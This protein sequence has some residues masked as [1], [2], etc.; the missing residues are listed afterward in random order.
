MISYQTLVPALKE[1]FPEAAMTEDYIV[2]NESV[3]YAF[4]SDLVDYLRD[5]YQKGA[6]NADDPRI[7]KMFAIITELENLPGQESREIVPAGFFESMLYGE[8]SDTLFVEAAKK[9]L[10]KSMWRLF[11]IVQTKHLGE[12]KEFVDPDEKGA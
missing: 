4:V 8:P 12:E 10:N 9:Y 11:R 7:A 5:E 2:E 6:I 3:P 1:I